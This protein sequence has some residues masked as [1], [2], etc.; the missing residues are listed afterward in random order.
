MPAAAGGIT[1]ICYSAPDRLGCLI[2]QAEFQRE[3]NAEIDA[4]IARAASARS[5]ELAMSLTHCKSRFSRTPRCMAE[6]A[7]RFAARQNQLIDASMARVAEVRAFETAR[8]A[9]AD[10]SAARVAAI[11]T[12]ELEARQNAIIAASIAA[13]EIERQRRFARQQNELA[14]ASIERVEIERRRQ[15]AVRMA[16]CISAT[17][18]RDRCEAQR[19]RVAVL[20][21]RALAT[22]SIER[23]RA[24]RERAFAAA[25]N[26][27]AAASIAAVER[28]RASGEF[29]RIETATIDTPA[30]AVTAEE[31]AALTSH[32]V[33]APD[34]PRCEAERIREFAAARN[35][36]IERSMAAAAAARASANDYAAYTSH[37]V[38][39]PDSPRCD[40]ERIREFAAARNAEINLSMAAVAA[41]RKQ[42]QHAS[43]TLIPAAGHPASYCASAPYSPVC[44][45]EPSAD[46]YASYT[47]HCVRAP[48]S[49]RCD[50]ERIRE[51]AAA[52]NVEIERSI[53]AARA[54][55]Q[56]ANA[57]ICKS[58][59]DTSPAC[60]SQREGNFTAARNAE[61]DRSIAAVAA[62][63][64]AGQLT[65]SNDTATNSG[66]T[67]IETGAISLPAQPRLFEMQHEPSNLMRHDIKTD[68]C[69][70]EPFDALQFTRGATL[71]SSMM[72][73]LDR[74]ST[75]AQ[76][77]PGVRIE[78]QGYAQGGSPSSNRS[79]AQSRAQAVADYLIANG[80]APN[81]VAAVG[82]GD[83]I[84]VM[85][86]GKSFAVSSGRA[87]LIVRDPGTDATARRVMWDLAELLDPNY[88]PAVAN[89]SP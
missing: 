21:Q 67:S 12:R 82:L 84:P 11:R 30:P 38:R 86:Y 70:T 85:L 35:A 36:E 58:T 69:R 25:R 4:S 88:I 68:P 16:P 62:A 65:Q 23:V 27:E 81:R 41:A 46:E 47:S 64:A 22:A 8:R 18:T 83:R 32:C 44:L 59:F 6:R 33:R 20:H 34:S 37:C 74:L 5:R 89:L 60:I 31:Y 14:T 72:P 87:E 26:A 3:R 7:Q 76:T 78:V 55:Q 40:A 42:A 63:R 80:V 53:A 10:A 13:V 61:I 29:S 71:E 1:D 73:Q 9:E 50:A 24:E 45:I 56:E 15:L 19:A 54:N 79:L 49:P 57:A 28:V 66:T 17:D 43:T 52:R 48:D 51:F 2:E 75:L 77:C 39:A